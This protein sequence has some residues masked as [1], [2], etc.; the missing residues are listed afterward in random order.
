[1]GTDT[2]ISCKLIPAW[3]VRT[4]RTYIHHQKTGQFTHAR[5]PDMR[6]ASKTQRYRTGLHLGKCAGPPTG[7]N[8][9]F[10]RTA[11]NWKQPTTD[12]APPFLCW[13]RQA[14]G[15]KGK[16]PHLSCF[17]QYRYTLQPLPGDSE[18]G[19]LLSLKTFLNSEDFYKSGTSEQSRKRNLIFIT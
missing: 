16:A 14:A 15:W 3:S 6:A 11:P 13:K 4:I 10:T 17:I 12:F 9:Q 1:M 5:L 19:L 2:C 7:C 8:Y 18:G